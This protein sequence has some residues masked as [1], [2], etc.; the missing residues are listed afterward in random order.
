[1]AVLIPEQGVYVPVPTFFQTQAQS[2]SLQ[3]SLDITTQAAHSVH[4]AKSGTTGLVL[5]GSTGEAIHLSRAERSS[6]IS[7]VRKA[8]D[9]AGFP[10]YPIISGVLINSIDETLEWLQDAA[11]AGSQ[12]G[13]VLAPGYFGN[14]VNQKNL[15]EWYTIVADQSPIPIIMLVQIR[16]IVSLDRTGHY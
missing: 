5:M 11:Q 13:L 9:D 15:I 14:F 4:L 6:L 7:S 10:K 1:M 3:P 12:W 16:Y 2:P 8:L